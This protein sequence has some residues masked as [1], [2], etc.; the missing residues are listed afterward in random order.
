MDFFLLISL[1]CKCGKAQSPVLPCEITSILIYFHQ[2]AQ[3]EQGE[4]GD[5][6]DPGPTVINIKIFF[7]TVVLLHL[8]QT[9]IMRQFRQTDKSKCS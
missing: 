5:E 8:R 3:G 4:I 7:H 2:G 9:Y 1:V 6:G